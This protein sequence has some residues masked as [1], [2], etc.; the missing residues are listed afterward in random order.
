MPRFNKENRK[1][2]TCNL[3][4]LGALGFWTILPKICP[5][6]LSHMSQGPW[7]C[8]CEGN[9]FL[10]RHI[11]DMVYWNLCQAYLPKVDLMQIPTNHEILFNLLCK[12]QCWLFIHD[13]FFRSL[14]LLVES[15]LG[16]SL[17]FPPMRDLRVQWSQAFRSCV[18]SSP[19]RNL[20]WCAKY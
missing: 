4:D 14:G 9:W 13:D 17:P 10:S 11:I 8:N 18:W 15:E 1:I 20:K 7:P 5:D 3:L 16:R 6:V 12:I 2:T 19:W